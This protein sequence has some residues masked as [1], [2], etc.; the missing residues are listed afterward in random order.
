MEFLRRRG[1][2]SP[3]PRR[4]DDPDRLTLVYFM[5]AA[6]TRE[7]SQRTRRR[8]ADARWAREHVRVGETERVTE[9]DALDD[10]TAALLL[11]TAAW[12]SP[13]ATLECR[14]TGFEPRRRRLVEGCRHDDGGVVV[15]VVVIVATAMQRRGLRFSQLHRAHTF[16]T[17]SETDA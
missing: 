11:A 10:E 6:R 2:A 7:N 1:S 13:P 3:L 5:L 15:V 9:R 14:P 17:S 16:C 8:A 4:T 12:R